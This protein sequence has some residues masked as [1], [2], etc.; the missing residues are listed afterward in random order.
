LAKIL[1]WHEQGLDFADALH[2][3]S[4]GSLTELITFDSK[5]IKRAKGLSACHV[6]LP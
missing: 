2:L 3:A 5:F 4:S 6:R 1:A